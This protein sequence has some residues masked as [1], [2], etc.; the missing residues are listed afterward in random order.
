MLSVCYRSRKMS[1]Q[2]QH[3]CQCYQS[4]MK[5][6]QQCPNPSQPGSDFCEKHQKCDQYFGSHPTFRLLSSSRG[7]TSRVSPS[8]SPLSPLD[9]AVPSKSSSLSEFSPLVKVPKSLKIFELSDLS[10]SKSSS[11]QLSGAYG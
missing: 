7:S 3:Q 9:S 1:I 2:H 6:H 11:K 8:P 10:I 5:L 4:S